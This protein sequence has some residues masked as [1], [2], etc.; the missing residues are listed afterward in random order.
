M[1]LKFNSK[2]AKPKLEKKQIK[3][4]TLE[5]VKKLLNKADHWGKYDYAIEWT[6]K[7]MDG[8]VTEVSVTCNPKI[9]MPI[10]AGWNKADKESQK[11]WD[12]MW[13][14]LK[15]HEEKHH[16]V[17]EKMI[18]ELS[19]QLSKDKKLDEKNLPAKMDKFLSDVQKEQKAYDKKS[20]HGKKEGVK[21]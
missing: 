10:W 5:D 17:T 1:K 2:L 13:V 14:K 4:A 11:K 19:K 6:Y 12:I 18:K 21:L 15:R 20:D 9:T 8:K 3:G 7:A 16:D